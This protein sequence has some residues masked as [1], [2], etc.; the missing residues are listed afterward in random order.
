MAEADSTAS[1][2]RLVKS[3]LRKERSAF[4]PYVVGTF[5]AT[6][7]GNTSLSQITVN[8]QL[9]R[10]VRKAKHVGNISVNEQCLCIQGFGQGLMIIAIITGDVTD[11]T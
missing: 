7:T 3:L 8:G 9:V 11:L 4:S 1:I 6:E 2:V 10:H 5:V